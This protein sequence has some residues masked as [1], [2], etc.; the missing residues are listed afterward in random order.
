MLRS[1]PSLFGTA[2]EPLWSL[3]YRYWFWD[4]L[5][6]DVNLGDPLRRRASWR[7]NVAMRSCLPTYMGRWLACAASTAMVAQAVEASTR[8]SMVP[9]IFYTG[10]VLGSVVFVVALTIWAFLARDR[11]T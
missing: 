5:F 3:L 11:H 10:S 1:D 8:A 6:H 2:R 7:H 4:W 9:A